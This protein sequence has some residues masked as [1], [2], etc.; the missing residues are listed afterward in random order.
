MSTLKQK[1]QSILDEKESKIIAENIKKDI[2]VFD[3]TGTY[4][5]NNSPSYFNPDYYNCGVNY[6]LQY[7]GTKQIQNGDFWCNCILAG[8]ERDAM[9]YP[10]G[11]TFF[12]IE[13]GTNIDINKSMDIRINFYDENNTQIYTYNQGITFTGQYSSQEIQLVGEST[14]SDLHIALQSAWDY[15]IVL[16]D[17]MMI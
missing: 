6:I 10:S 9:S 15:D 17:N 8:R 5:G 13:V 7:S 1:A 16:T 2:T 14:S 4:E 12:K 11:R 3:I